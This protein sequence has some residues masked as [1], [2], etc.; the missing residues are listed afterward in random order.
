MC[1]LTH[2]RMQTRDEPRLFV[3]R[4]RGQRGDHA[5]SVPHDVPV[6]VKIGERALH[7]DGPR[8]DVLKP[9]A[10]PEGLQHVKP[11]CLGARR[12]R[13]RYTHRL[14]GR[15]DRR[16]RK[17][18]PLHVPRIRTHQAP[19]RHHARHLRHADRRIGHKENHQRHHRRVERVVVER[20]GHRR[21]HTPCCRLERRPSARI[22]QL[23]LGRVHAR[24]LGRGATRDH[25]LRKRPVAAPDIQPALPGWRRQ[26]LQKVGAHQL[27][28]HAHVAFVGRAVIK[29]NGSRHG[30]GPCG[31]SN[32]RMAARVRASA[33]TGE[34][35]REG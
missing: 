14:Q 8:V 18:T 27:A 32:A 11:R 23:C 1:M 15:V 19:G 5:R 20:Q 6:F 21:T 22:G 13:H 17:A 33:M 4:Q 2:L 10:R 9:R 30:A 25:Q 28:P 31:W 12:G 3:G 34:S 29:A 35:L 16:V 7:R 26:P 24:H